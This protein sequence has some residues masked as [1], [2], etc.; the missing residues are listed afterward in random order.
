MAET[1]CEG[2]FFGIDSGSEQ[3]QQAMN[4]RLDLSEAALRIERTDKRGIKTTVSLITGFPEETKDDL[5]ATI[6][7]LVDSL[8]FDNSEPQLHLLA[9]LA[10]TPITTQYKDKLIFDDIFSDTSYQ[11]WQQEVPDREM[12][13]SYPDIFVNFYAVPTCCF[14]RHYLRELREFILKGMRE[15]RWLF[16]TLHQDYGD[17]VGV[18]DQWKS[19]YQQNRGD[20]LF[21][22]CDVRTY[23]FSDDFREEFLGFVR[24]YYLPRMASYPMAISAILSYQ[25]ALS[26]L[27]KIQGRPPEEDAGEIK[28][29]RLG[30]RPGTRPTHAANMRVMHMDIDFE[31]LQG[32]L[33]RRGRLDQV[34]ATPVTVVFRLVNKRVEVV[35][36][37]Q[38]SARLLALCDG[39]HA[40]SDIVNSFSAGEATTINIPA[41]KVCLFGLTL[42]H[43]RGLIAELV[44]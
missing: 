32:S 19:W 36:L 17:L 37:S 25:S 22:D 14:D 35:Q 20:N 29:Q 39:A 12:I 44:Y 11:G 26:D 4:K 13:R 7:F 18:F 1:G 30:L 31:E 3:L 42:L 16:V 2:V 34:P 27:D 28:E 9:P 8:R 40:L 24:S 6:G 15:F 23:Y 21:P 33:R 41:D 10:E 5:R 38:D 43:E